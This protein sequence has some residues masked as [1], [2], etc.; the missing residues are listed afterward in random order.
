MVNLRGFI[1][2]LS[3]SEKISVSNQPQV[4][5]EMSLLFSMNFIPL[6]FVFYKTIFCFTNCSGF[7]T[8][9]HKL[10]MESQ[11]IK[12]AQ[13]QETLPCIH[14]TTFYGST[15]SKEPDRNQEKCFSNFIYSEIEFVV[16]VVSEDVFK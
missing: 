1:N 6:R 2:R 8:V 15:N 14:N 7:K 10:I 4:M 13:K 3:G 11:S 5:L 16:I 9:K 12:V